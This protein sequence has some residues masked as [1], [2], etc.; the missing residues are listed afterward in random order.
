MLINCRTIPK[1]FES[2]NNMFRKVCCS[3]LGFAVLKIQSLRFNHSMTPVALKLAKS[4]GQTFEYFF[5]PGNK[6]YLNLKK[7]IYSQ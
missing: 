7:N 3:N 6:L 4:F 1:A 2:E 5:G